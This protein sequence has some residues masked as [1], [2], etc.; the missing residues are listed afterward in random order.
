MTRLK[1]ILEYIEVSDCNMEEGSLRCGRTTHRGADG[2]Q[3]LPAGHPAHVHNGRHRDRLVFA[4]RDD[5]FTGRYLR[6]LLPLDDTAAAKAPERAPG[7]DAKP[8][9]G[10]QGD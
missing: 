2:F 9:K 4:V 3:R 7:Y 8:A 1:A 6:R 5:Y 10:G